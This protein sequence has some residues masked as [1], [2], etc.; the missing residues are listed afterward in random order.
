MGWRNHLEVG[1][2]ATALIQLSLIVP[3]HNEEKR[4][5]ATLEVYSQELRRAYG[6]EGFEIIVV[7]NGSSDR[8]AAVARDSG[9]HF[10]QVSLIEIPEAIGKGGAV[11]EGFRHARGRAMAFTDA[12]AATAPHSIVELAERTDEYDVVIGSR[13][14]PGSVI[15]RQ[16]PFRRRVFGQAFVWTAQLLFG[17]PY[18]DTQCG[19]KALRPEAA[20]RLAALV[21]ERHWTFDL[22]LLLTSRDL[23]LRVGQYPV[24]WA[25]QPGSRL[26][27]LPTLCDVVPSLWRMARRGMVTSRQVPIL[28][29]RPAGAPGDAVYEPTLAHSGL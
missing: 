19:A 21:R 11:L 4:L 12:D 1:S 16:Q 3:A 20:S 15:T 8:T 2:G 17:L 14:M 22:D 29:S 5:A 10:P 28:H 6:D 13:R 9:R 18:A 23:G 27:F 26:R 24:Q 25:D 7:S